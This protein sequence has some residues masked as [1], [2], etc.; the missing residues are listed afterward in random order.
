MGEDQEKNEKIQ[1][2]DS[3]HGLLHSVKHL[4]ILIDV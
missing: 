3:D 2:T 4:K 1:Q